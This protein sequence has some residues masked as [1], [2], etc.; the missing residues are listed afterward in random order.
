MTL[1]SSTGDRE[2][3]KFEE[4]EG[5]TKVR[6]LTH[7]EGG[8][9]NVSPSGLQN[10]FRT[11][12]MNISDVAAPIPALPLTDRNSLSIANLDEQETV[13][14]GDLNVTADRGIGNTAGWEIGPGETLNFDVKDTIILY[15]RAEAGKTILIKV[16]E[17]S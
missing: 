1:S 14:I 15:G 16:L 6:T 8:I 13:Y 11:T 12:T 10:S 17:A 5:K 7:I 2:R 4:H 9:V 3:E